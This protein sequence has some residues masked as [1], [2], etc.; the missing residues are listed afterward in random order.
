MCVLQAGAR[1]EHETFRHPPSSWESLAGV[2]QHPLI[3]RCRLG[4]CT[5]FTV[6]STFDCC[7]CIGL[8]SGAGSLVNVGTGSLVCSAR[9]CRLQH[10]VTLIDD[11]CRRPFFAH[12]YFT[13][14]FVGLKD[15][16]ACLVATNCLVDCESV[17][18][19]TVGPTGRS[20]CE[21]RLVDAS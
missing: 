6:M 12:S 7:R 3:L 18:Y 19:G 5:D 16:L 20:S 15:M 21:R 2:L 9:F 1:Y 17:E 10:V 11:D 4:L 14:L 13:M 8:V